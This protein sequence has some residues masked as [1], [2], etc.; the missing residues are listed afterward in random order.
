MAALKQILNPQIFR[1][2]RPIKE[3]AGLGNG[4]GGGGSELCVIGTGFGVRAHR[5]MEDRG[6]TMLRAGGG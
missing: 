1:G 6:R 4:G 3:G 2:E 5:P